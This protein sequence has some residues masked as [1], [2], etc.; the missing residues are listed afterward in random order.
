[1][2][3]NIQKIVNITYNIAKIKIR[4]AIYLYSVYNEKNTK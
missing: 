3:K 2:Q 1:M 4:L